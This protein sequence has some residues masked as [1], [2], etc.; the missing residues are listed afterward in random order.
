MTQGNFSDPGMVGRLLADLRLAL[1]F[2]TRL[3]VRPREGDIRPLGAVAYVFPLAGAF[4]GLLGGLAF[5]VADWIGLPSLLAAI[6]AVAATVL[7]TGGLHEDALGDVA[8]GFGAGGGRD[9]ILAIMRD[10]RL[11]TYGALA[12]ILATAARIAALATLPHPTLV[13]AAL[14]AAGAA[15]RT[16]ATALMLWLPPARSDGLGAGAGRPVPDAVYIGITI[17]S[18]AVWLVLGLGALI[19][20]AILGGGAAWLVGILAKRRIGGQTGDVLGA[21]VLACEIG[22]LLAAVIVLA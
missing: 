6:I 13:L 18:L 15:S 7:A 20:G 9:R 8:D 19:L 5:G 1:V 4:V 2:L 3:P 22:V 12:L 17:A 21:A 11:G 14:I 16:A 10:S